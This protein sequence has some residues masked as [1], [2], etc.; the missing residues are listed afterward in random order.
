MRFDLKRI[1][2]RQR[3]ASLT[4]GYLIVGYCQSEILKASV[5]NATSYEGRL[6]CQ[7]FFF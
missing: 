7:T 2:I 5:G 4:V 6:L 1:P 3:R